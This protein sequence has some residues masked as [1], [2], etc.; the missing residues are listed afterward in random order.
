MDVRESELSVELVTGIADV[1]A[2]KGAYCGGI[3]ATAQEKGG[4]PASFLGILGRLAAVVALQLA[5]RQL[6]PVAV[7]FSDGRGNH[8]VSDPV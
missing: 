7:K 6:A 4:T 8:P 1:G 5:P 3:E 2:R